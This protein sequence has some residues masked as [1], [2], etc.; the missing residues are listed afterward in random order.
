[1]KTTMLISFLLI[2]NILSA[3]S[4]NSNSKKPLDTSIR[5]ESSN[6]AYA[7]I[8]G[9]EWDDHDS[10]GFKG[11]VNMK[12]GIVLT[13]SIDGITN[14]TN[15][16]STSSRV[17]EAQMFIAK[18]L[19]FSYQNI[20][21]DLG[22]A[23]G[24]NATGKFG[25]DALQ[26]GWHSSSGIQR[27][28]PE[29][30][31]S[32]NKLD[33]SLNAIARFSL[34]KAISPFVS[35]EAQSIGIESINSCL[36]AGIAYDGL[37]AAVGYQ[38][39]ASTASTALLNLNKVDTGLFYT[40]DCTSGMLYF[41]FNSHPFNNISNG[42]IGVIIGSKATHNNSGLGMDFGMMLGSAPSPSFQLLKKFQTYDNLTP[43]AYLQ[44]TGG[45][46]GNVASGIGAPRFEEYSLG[47]ALDSQILTSLFHARL[48]L[49][50]NVSHEELRTLTCCT[51]QVLD[52]RTILSGSIVAEA[53]ASIFN[54]ISIGS[55]LGFR[56]QY[57][58]LTVDLRASSTSF[59]TR[60][61]LQMEIFIFSESN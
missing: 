15:S 44:V 32:G 57:S 36:A 28:V 35:I 33:P 42:S 38:L 41:S 39:Q 58:P 55:G 47:I 1:M 34:D 17:D 53:R 8:P 12:N 6:D 25:F 30:Y 2:T 5:I 13:A 50:A 31:D 61:P 37:D 59:A 4:F 46:I 3:Q 29:S 60:S 51:S 27:P 49:K 14:R 54:F 40:V 11:I 9:I 10:Y 24:V 16:D 48:G 22:G 21:I 19:P 45:W 18:W 56:A 52:S 23:I 43:I 20:N 7:P 26:S